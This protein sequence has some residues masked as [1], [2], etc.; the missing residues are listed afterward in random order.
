MNNKIKSSLDTVEGKIMFCIVREFLE[1]FNLDYTLSVYEPESYLDKNFQ[2]KERHIVAEELG[3][4]DAE[5][6]QIPLLLSLIRHVKLTKTQCKDQNSSST[7]ELQESQTDNS[8]HLQ[9]NLNSTYE[10]SHP[11]INLYS[12]GN[13]L[14]E[15]STN[16]VLEKD[17]DL[18][19]DGNVDTSSQ[20]VLKDSRIGEKN[21]GDKIRTK[22]TSLPEVAP[23]QNNKSRVSDI[24]PSLYNKDHIDKPGFRELDKMFDIEADYEEDFMYSSDIPSKCDSKSDTIDISDIKLSQSIN[25]ELPDVS[26]EEPSNVTTT[27]ANSKSENLNSVKE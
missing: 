27:N 25:T 5:D 2:Y 20:P 15:I 7:S 9:K 17:D 13:E 23:L 24:L 4:D 3:L 12:S 19:T 21:K 14:N 26:I 11:T 6:S 1:Y 18:Q 10:L 22:G 16:L 8:K